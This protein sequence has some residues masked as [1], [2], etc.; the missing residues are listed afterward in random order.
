[1]KTEVEQKKNQVR[2][3]NR[4]AT[5]FKFNH[6]KH[7]NNG[8]ICCNEGN[9][10]TKNIAVVIVRI[11]ANYRWPYVECQYAFSWLIVAQYEFLR[12]LFLLVLY[13]DEVVLNYNSY[14]RYALLTIT[15]L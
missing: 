14:L 11:E 2:L 5:W 8:Y 1:M 9:T 3:N 4:N 12:D 7:T 15:Q 6:W 13:R 10:A